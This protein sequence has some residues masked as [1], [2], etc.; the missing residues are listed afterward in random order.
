MHEL[1][2]AVNI[3]EIAEAEAKQA[4]ADKV[5]DVEIEAGIFSG[6][7]EE[8]LETAL[9]LASKDTI[10]ENS[11]FTIRKT[12]GTGICSS[13]GREFEMESLYSF[14]GECHAPANR[15]VQ[16]TDLRILAIK[17]D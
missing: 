14:C 12:T 15:I 17:V 8:A 3:V 1:T 11:S 5:Y 9:S 7:D 13:C 4:G 2:L 16:G 6:V 10:L